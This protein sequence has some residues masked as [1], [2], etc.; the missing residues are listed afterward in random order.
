MCT[1]SGPSG[2]L[3]AAD[4]PLS[5]RFRGFPGVKINKHQ[6]SADNPVIAHAFVMRMLTLHGR[7]TLLLN[8]C[9]VYSWNDP[10]PMEIQ[11]V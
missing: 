11:D 9:L 8:A 2:A 3:A 4:N 6:S 10:F 7:A 5:K 1:A